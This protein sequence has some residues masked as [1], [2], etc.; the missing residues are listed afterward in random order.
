MK[1]SDPHASVRE[2]DNLTKTKK[3]GGKAV[4]IPKGTQ[5]HVSE[6]QHGALKE[7][8]GKQDNAQGYGVFAKVDGY[9]WTLLANLKALPPKAP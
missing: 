3:S 8:D 7:H 5:L 6:Y 2:D 4:E 9:G 1:W